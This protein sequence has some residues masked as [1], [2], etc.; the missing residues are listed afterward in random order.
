MPTNPTTRVALYARVSDV[1]PKFGPSVLEVGPTLP[2]PS[3][4]A[5]LS[6]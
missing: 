3:R 1:P 5:P 4:R 6:G 2:A